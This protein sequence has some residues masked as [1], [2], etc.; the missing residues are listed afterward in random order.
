MIFRS[1]REGG[2]GRGRGEG[3]SLIII[4]TKPFGVF[5][6]C[7]CVHVCLCFCFGFLF[8]PFLSLFVFHRK[9]IVL[10]HLINRYITFTSCLI[11]EK[12]RHSGKQFFDIIK[13]FIH[14][15]KD[16]YS[17]HIAVVVNIYLYGCVILLALSVLCI[18]VCDIK[19][20]YQQKVTLC[21]RPQ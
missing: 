4:L 21:V 18:S 3:G 20:K 9:N 13:L 17:E 12:K 6:V 11:F 7:V 19:S 5:G 15:I 10:W 16:S 8:T 1:L 2:G 14:C